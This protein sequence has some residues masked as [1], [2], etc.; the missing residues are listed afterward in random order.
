MVGILDN[1]S[2]PIANEI[3]QTTLSLPISFCH[4]KDDIYKVV[5]IMNAF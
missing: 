2:T 5:E 1:Q 4:T 3:H